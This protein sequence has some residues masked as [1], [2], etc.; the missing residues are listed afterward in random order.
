MSV[1]DD[2]RQVIL[3]KVD[4]GAAIVAM[5]VEWVARS[6]FD[7]FATGDETIHMQWLGIEMCKQLAR[8]VMASKFDAD[9]DENPAHQADMFS[10]KLQD[11]Y[12]VQ[13]SAG[14]APIYKRREAL[15]A[16]EIDW[17]IGQLLKSADAR[18]R[19]ADALRAYRGERFAEAA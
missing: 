6:V 15:T 2:I 14:E 19:H 3:R 12:P 16:A 18:Q 4:E 5:P 8:K 13:R 11:R 9:G 1:H 17:N 7:E 10:G